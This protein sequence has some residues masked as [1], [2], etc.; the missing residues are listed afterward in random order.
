MRMDE[1]LMQELKVSSALEAIHDGHMSRR[2]GVC[3]RVEAGSGTRYGDEGVF[4][5][6]FG[7]IQVLLARGSLLSGC[8][9]TGVQ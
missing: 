3:R 1:Y 4:D 7:I 5:G 2:C 6:V 9:F 8:F